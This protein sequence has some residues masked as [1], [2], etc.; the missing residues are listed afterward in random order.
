M[1]TWLNA[2][3]ASGLWWVRRYGQR[4]DVLCVTRLDEHAVWISGTLHTRDTL[5]TR[6]TLR[7]WQWCRVVAPDV[8]AEIV[9]ERDHYR[10]RAAEHHRRGDEARH[11]A[12]TLR[13]RVAALESTLR[14]ACETWRSRDGAPTWCKRCGAAWDDEAHGHGCPVGRALAVLRGATVA[15]ERGSRG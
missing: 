9:R 10:E 12:A 15:G 7:G 13:D 2:P 4:D 8:H 6:D 11:E 3:D 5:C 1:T 14:E